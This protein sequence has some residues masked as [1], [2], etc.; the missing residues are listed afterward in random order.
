M[1]PF[2]IYLSVFRQVWEA[3][4]LRENPSLLRATAKVWGG[5][6]L[7]Q[8]VPCVIA[9]VMDLLSPIILQLC[10]ATLTFFGDHFPR[11]SALRHPSRAV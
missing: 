6:F 9:D 7:L 10:T 11:L 3:E 1:F 8:A 5:W 2:K 4:L